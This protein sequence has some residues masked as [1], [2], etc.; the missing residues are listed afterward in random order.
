M[1]IYKIDPITDP[2]WMEL[3][4]RHP[5]SSI[6][7]TRGW[8]SALQRTYGYEPI[9]FTTS[10]PGS[11]LANGFPFCHVDNWP[12]GS[13]LVSLPFSDHCRLLLTDS[14]DLDCLLT[15]LQR[16]LADKRWQYIE[17][18]S[19]GFDM[20]KPQE[21]GKAESFYFHAIDL[22]PS[23]DEIF[24]RFHRDCVQRKV[25]RAESENLT[26]EEGRSG[27]LLN[28]FYHLLLMTRRRQRLPPQPIEWFRN[29]ISCLGDAITIRVA[30]KDNK[31]IASILTLRHR[32]SMVYKYGCSDEKFNNLGGTQLL[33]WRTIR[34]A[35]NNNLLEFDM[36]R[37][38]IDNSGLITF[39]DRWG[40]ARSVL[41]YWRYPRL[42]RRVYSPVWA[43]WAASK[44]LAYMPDRMLTT[45]GKLLYKH[46]G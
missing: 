5:Q 36:G 7:H 8:L 37:S 42:S 22:R 12:A 39:K 18:R 30:L 1:R 21:Y 17:I 6:F 2:R 28:K 41:T 46:A 27:S 20:A 40:A 33:L 23:L 38:D 26:Y 29:L 44:M 4:Q 11:D 45:A 15:A 13:R 19:P 10:P 3:Q 24:R 14:E 34:E 16:Q 25:H 32:E 9:A 35:K 31:P 43:R